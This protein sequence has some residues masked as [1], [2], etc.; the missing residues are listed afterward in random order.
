MG[1]KPIRCATRAD[2]TAFTEFLLRQSLA[3]RCQIGE[4]ARWLKPRPGVW[5]VRP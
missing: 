1:G 5:R 4:T 3:A 2:L